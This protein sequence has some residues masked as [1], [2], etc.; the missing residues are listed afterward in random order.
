MKR[1]I[2]LLAAL[3]ATSLVACGDDDD[4]GGNEPVPGFPKPAGTVTVN[5]KVDDS[6]N[7]VWKAGEIEWKGTVQFDPATRIGTFD[8]SW[9]AED[10]GWAILYDDGPWDVGPNFGHEPSGAVAGDHVWGVTVFIAPPAATDA[11]TCNTPAGTTGCTKYSYGLRDATNPDRA[12]GGWIWVGSNGSFNIAAGQ[13]GT[14]N[15]PGLTFPAN[16]TKDLKLVLDVNAL[17]PAAGATPPFD[18]VKVKGSAWGWSLKDGFDDGTHLDAT[19]GDGKYTFVL[20][21][22]ID[23]TMPPY[24]GLLKTGDQPEFVW[25]L[26]GV[27]YK[28][29]PDAP[30]EGN[31][32]QVKTGTTW[33]D[34]TVVQVTG[35]LGGKNTAVVVP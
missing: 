6:A 17:L 24:P 8:G 26:D 16:G 7:K 29:G 35:G 27:E 32:A 19:A 1:I 15:A 5:F 31:A 28:N 13:T 30:L 34:V 14:V 2:W 10:P 9:L 22:V 11:D 3:M 25:E 4:D 18:T 21:D 23:S 33:A 12:N 20:S